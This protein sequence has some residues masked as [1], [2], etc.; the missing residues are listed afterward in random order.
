MA[1]ATGP[2]DGGI[3]VLQLLAAVAAVLAATAALTSHPAAQAL[4]RRTPRPRARVMAGGNASVGW[5]DPA[6]FD[7][8]G[9]ES[10]EDE[11]KLSLLDTGLRGYISNMGWL[12]ADARHGPDPPASFSSRITWQGGCPTTAEISV[13]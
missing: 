7:R 13:Q 6:E 12:P 1:P 4:H 11:R 9:D 2:K 8:L 10:P 5:Q 3:T